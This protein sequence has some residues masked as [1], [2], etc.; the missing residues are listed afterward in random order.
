M[1]SSRAKT[2]RPKAFPTKP[3]ESYLPY[4]PVP[5]EGDAWN[6]VLAA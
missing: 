3:R 1:A 5:L 4:T 6:A 2:K